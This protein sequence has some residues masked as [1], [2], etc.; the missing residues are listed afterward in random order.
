MFLILCTTS[1]AAVY[2]G[3]C[4]PVVQQLESTKPFECVV[5][6]HFHGCAWEEWLLGGGSQKCDVPSGHQN[7]WPDHKFS[8]FWK[9][10]A[11]KH[12]IGPQAPSPTFK[13]GLLNLTAWLKICVF[14]FNMHGFGRILV[15]KLCSYFR[16]PFSCMFWST[17]LKCKACCCCWKRAY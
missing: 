11:T 1:R 6:H 2:R 17:Q 15:R 13:S 8:L 4:H 3:I 12:G 14:V 16:G 9:E 5:C 7:E 10:K